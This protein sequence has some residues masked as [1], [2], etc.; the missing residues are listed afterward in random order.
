MNERTTTIGKLLEIWRYP[1]S[2]LAGE[3]L[4]LARMDA[5]GLRGDRTHALFE[6]QSGQMAYPSLM[7]KW[8]IAPALNAR[9]RDDSLIELSHDRQQWFCEGETA[10]FDRLEGIIGTRVGLV[11]YGER[12]GSTVAERRYSMQPIHLLSRQSL[13]AK[14]KRC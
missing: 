1:V 9:T 2:S 12:V 3:R 5:G 13:A 11:R 7:R 6:L 14:R 8:N 10:F 4:E